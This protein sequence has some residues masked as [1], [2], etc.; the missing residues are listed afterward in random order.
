M[1]DDLCVALESASRGWTGGPATGAML[2]A[3]RAFLARVADDPALLGEVAA[4]LTRYEP[5]AAAWIA[6]TCGTAVE[7]GAPADSTG[8]AV[9]D[10]LRSSLAALPIGG[11]A[12]PPHEP[13][14]EQA[15]HLE[16]FSY[17]CQA[18]VTHLAR[19]PVPR[20]AM[21]RDEAL[22]DRLGELQAFSHGAV[23]VREALLKSSGTL[24]FL[25]PPSGT[26]LRLCYS[27][28]SNC[29]HLFSLLQTAIGERV[30]GGRVP[31]AAIARV[32]RGTSTE[33]VNDAAW[34]HYGTAESKRAE[35]STG[36]LGEGL[37]RD[38]PAVDGPQIIV[39]WPPLLESRGWDGGF[40]GPHLEA[41]P[42]DVVIDGQLAQ[43]ESEAW[44]KRLGVGKQK[45]WW[46]RG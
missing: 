7:R 36:I 44:L 1:A 32:A 22:L 29:F 42:A 45:R 15:A 38:I 33:P 43:A 17:L 30:P 26:G 21:S 3:T 18:A 34:W 16:L 46:R 24:V 39:A 37:V 19:L 2:A 27:N 8:P 35:L 28:V 6:V 25:H 10:L 14:R 23:W 9:L 4:S 5:G 11:E 12:D 31:V 13:T 40:L 20:E 41:M